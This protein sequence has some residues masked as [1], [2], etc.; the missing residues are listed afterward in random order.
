MERVDWLGRVTCSLLGGLG[1]PPLGHVNPEWVEW[2]RKGKRGCC[3]LRKTRASQG[4][5]PPGLNGKGVS[6]APPGTQ[7]LKTFSDLGLFALDVLFYFSCFLQTGFL[8]LSEH[9]S[10][11]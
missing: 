5:F 2:F 8:C 7:K 1:Q 11:L 4:P 10:A 6:L 9:I 3:S